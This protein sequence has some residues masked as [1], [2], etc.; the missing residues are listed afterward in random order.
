MR[1][2]FSYVEKILMFFSNDRKAFRHTHSLKA[3]VFNATI[4]Y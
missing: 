3:V 2:G 1:R 4:P